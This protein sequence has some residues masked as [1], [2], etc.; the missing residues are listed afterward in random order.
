MIEKFYTP[1]GKE[2]STFYDGRNLRVK[3]A[4]GGEL[5]ECLSGLYTNPIVAKNA[6]LKKIVL[7][8]QPGR[9]RVLDPRD[10]F[11]YLS[12]LS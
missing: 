11:F 1:N 3:F 10:P 5:P 2:I 4:T 8:Q 7:G 6:I 12:V 9:L